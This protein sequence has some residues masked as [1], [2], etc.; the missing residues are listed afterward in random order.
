[1][2]SQVAFGA[3]KNTVVSTTIVR[4]WRCLALA[5]LWLRC[6]GFGFAAL[7]TGAALARADL[8]TL[9][10]DLASR[11]GSHAGR[12]I[13]VA[14]RFVIPVNRD[15]R[16]AP[17]RRKLIFDRQFVRE[18]E[19]RQH[20]FVNAFD[21]G[22]TA[23]RQGPIRGAKNMHT[24]VANETSAKIVEATPIERQIKT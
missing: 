11:R 16:H 17:A 22:G 12:Q 18:C 1:I 13:S 20:V 19:R 21:A 10:F 3:N 9:T 24:P 5:A 7:T 2:R 8:R 14:I 6:R 15:G 4:A 23:Q